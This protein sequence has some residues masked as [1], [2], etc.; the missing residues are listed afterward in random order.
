MTRVGFDRFIGIDWSGA[1]TLN[2]GIQVA[3]YSRGNPH[4]EIVHPR[5]AACWTRSA[6]AGYIKSL[7][8]CRTLVGLDFAF[9]APTPWPVKTEKAQE[10]WARVDNFCV[11]STDWYTGDYYAAPIWEKEDSPFRPYFRYDGY[12]GELFDGRRRRR[13]ELACRP[14]AMSIYRLLYSQVGRG[15]F[16][17]MRML[18][19]LSSCASDR[20]AVW[21]FDEILSREL[22]IVEVYPSAFYR[23]ADCRRPNPKTQ[24]EEEVSRVVDK[25]LGRFNLACGTDQPR[26]QDEIDAYV[27]AAALAYLS[28]ENSNF[29]VPDDACG[30][31]A[32]EGWIFGVP[33]GGAA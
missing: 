20:I 10:L 4:P 31:I 17:G 5:N 23:M 11:E 7:S 26:S 32:K 28:N 1:R 15:S 27:T 6:V 3:A 19:S 16:A 18:K 12:R 29:S 21:P 24:T 2:G 14:H 8:G 30:L 22:V 25:T 9:S 13:A 33:F